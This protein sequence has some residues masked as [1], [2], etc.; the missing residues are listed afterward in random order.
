MSNQTIPDSLLRQGRK[1]SSTRNSMR[2]PIW[3]SNA[4]EWYLL[5]RRTNWRG[6][7]LMKLVRCWKIKMLLHKNRYCLLTQ[8]HRNSPLVQD[9]GIPN[10]VSYLQDT[11]TRCVG[12]TQEFMNKMQQ[13]LAAW[14]NTSSISSG[15]LNGIVTLPTWRVIWLDWH[16]YNSNR[17][18]TDVNHEGH[19]TEMGRPS[20]RM[21]TPV[22]FRARVR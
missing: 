2:V 8:L 16:P 11:Q 6:T 1:W 10:Q 13:L 21:L 18:G 4:V 5:V 20:Q 3:G 15:R 7:P 12:S 14:R 19:H 22:S 17:W 9:I